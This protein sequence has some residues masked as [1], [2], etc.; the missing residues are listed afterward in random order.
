VT[1]RAAWRD[2][3]KLATDQS[4]DR[5][6]DPELLSLDI[7]EAAEFGY[8][9]TLLSRVAVFGANG[10]F[11]GRG[12]QL[13]GDALVGIRQPARKNAR[14][15]DRSSVMHLNLKVKLDFQYELRETAAKNR[16]KMQ[17][18][19]GQAFDANAFDASAAAKDNL[20]QRCRSF[21]QT[22]LQWD[23]VSKIN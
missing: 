13:L 21:T 7:G 1:Q 14:I 22:V 15:V 3:V 6:V 8:S 9:A 12:L 11:A 16:V 5:L 4:A 23:A 10:N 20:R 17:D 19:L 18:L 2:L